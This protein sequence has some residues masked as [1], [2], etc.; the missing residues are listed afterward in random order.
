MTDSPSVKADAVAGSGSRGFDDGKQINGRKRHVVVDTFGLLIAVMV[1]A[2]DVGD[3]AAAQV[4]LTQVT[5]AHHPLTLVWADGAYTGS[6]VEYCLAT[7][8]L[9]L[10]TV[11]VIVKGSDDMRRFVVLPKR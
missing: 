7:L 2:T 9:V 11:I 1:T 8:P 3:R 6:L 10:V 5:A 4:L